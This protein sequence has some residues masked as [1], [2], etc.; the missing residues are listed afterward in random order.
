VEAIPMRRCVTAVRPFA[1][2]TPGAILNRAGLLW[3]R[4]MSALLDPYR[5]EQHY[6]RG[7]GPKYF[8]R[9]ARE[10][11]GEP[12]S[13]AHST[14]RRSRDAGTR[15]TQ[16]RE[17]HK[18]YPG[19]RTLMVLERAVPKFGPLPESRTYKCIQCGC[20]IEEDINQ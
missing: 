10:R 7:P 9:E 6:M 4:L 3:L 2:P 1:L 5:P 13:M 12:R 8:E 18:Y 15:P 16:E 11:M 20:V 19:C 17:P 14:I